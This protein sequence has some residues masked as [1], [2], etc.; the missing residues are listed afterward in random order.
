MQATAFLTCNPP[1]SLSFVLKIRVESHRIVLDMGS[2][3][4]EKAKPASDRYVPPPMDPYA[5]YQTPYERRPTDDQNPFIEFRRF[6]DKQFSSIFENFGEFPNFSRMFGFSD[7]MQRMR[8]HSDKFKEDLEKH[9][10]DLAEQ[11]QK[12]MKDFWK[13]RREIARRSEREAAT[14]ARDFNEHLQSVMNQSSRA[15]LEA[16]QLLSRSIEA[17]ISPE[18]SEDLPDGW[19]AATTRDG[20]SFYIEQATGKALSN[21]PTLEAVSLPK[22]WEMASAEDGRTYFIDHT[23]RTTSWDD[24]RAL[25]S[26]AAQDTSDRDSR[27]ERWRRGFQNCPALTEAAGDTELDMYELHDDQQTREDIWARGLQHCPDLSLNGEEKRSHIDAAIQKGDLATDWKNIWRRSMNEC[28]GLSQLTTANRADLAAYI[29]AERAKNDAPGCRWQTDRMSWFGLPTLGYDGMQKARRI[30]LHDDSPRVHESTHAAIPTRY[31]REDTRYMDPFARDDHLF[32]WL[33]LSPYSPFLI[34][35][36]ETPESATGFDGLDQ[37]VQLIGKVDCNETYKQSSQFNIGLPRSL[38]PMWQD[39][40]EDLLSISKTGDMVDR[41]GQSKHRACSRLSW[42]FQAIKRGSLGPH[43]TII[44]PRE[45]QCNTQSQAPSRLLHSLAVKHG[46]DDLT[47]EL[48]NSQIEH[49]TNSNALVRKWDASLDGST[50]IA[51]IDLW[52]LAQSMLTRRLYEIGLQQSR[53]PWKVNIDSQNN[54]N[55]ILELYSDDNATNFVAENDNEQ[56]GGS[57]MDEATI[58]NRSWSSTIA[59]SSSWPP[60]E[61]GKPSIISTMTTTTKKS[62]PDGTIESSTILKKTFSDGSEVTE[63]WSDPTERLSRSGPDSVSPSGSADTSF[64]TQ[65]KSGWFWN[66]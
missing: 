4:E 62:R 3:Q 53:V 34:G 30:T 8:E 7:E 59:S 28:S 65:R 66:S 24:P 45:I 19:V 43:W 60:E 14:S 49:D 40:F 27:R 64:N 41:S 12:M 5:I 9:I 61:S 6:A 13:E 32:P 20:K 63:Q 18:S 22:G 47:E 16:Q 56:V 29:A 36:Q 37:P 23:T 15:L 52:S 31:S 51:G 10:E 33:W 46:L 21:R 26:T 25:D 57:D 35:R 38:S 50:N 17:P 48:D 1:I 11:R 2:P 55:S 54:H 39:A 58:S 42:P 44:G